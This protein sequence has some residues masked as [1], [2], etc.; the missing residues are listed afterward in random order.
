MIACCSCSVAQSCP[1]LFDPVFCGKPGFTVSQSLRACLNSCPLSRWCHPTI[2]PS[3]TRL[4]SWPQSF[5][6]SESFPVSRLFASG[7]QSIGASVSAS[8]LPMSIQGWFFLFF[9]ID[10]FDLLGS[11]KFSPIPQL[12]SIS[13][14]VL[15]LLYGPAL[16]PICDYWNKHSF[17]YADFC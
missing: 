8:V 11:L 14:L 3:F 9:R 5:P 2:L 16:T 17:D 10:W 13:T 15:S 12:E 1:T 4:S 7:G 6:A